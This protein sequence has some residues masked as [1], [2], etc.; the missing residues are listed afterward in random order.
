MDSLKLISILML[1]FLLV[2]E[3]VLCGGDDFD[4]NY[5]I[6]WGFDHVINH[7]RDVHLQL[8]T[9]SGAGFASKHNFGSGFFNMRI[10]LHNK[11]TAGVVTA[12][13]LTSGGNQHDEVDFEFLGDKEGKPIKLQTN[14][15]ANGRGNKEQRISLWFDPAAE[16]HTYGILWNH[17]QIV[18]YV[19]Q[20]PIR[21]FKNNKKMKVGYPTQAMSIQGSIWCGDSWATDGGKTK[22]NWTHAPFLAHFEGGFHIDGCPADEGGTDVKSCYSGRKYWWSSPSYWNLSPEEW[23][24]YQLHK[25]KFITYDYCTDKSRNPVPPLSAL[26]SEGQ[27]QTTQ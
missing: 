21:V 13:Y 25:R 6:T 18:F 9:S 14:V 27:K 10:K 20:I 12:F 19:D 16:Y 11:D 7:E 26:H 1:G 5:K 23:S 4:D 8:D 2:C 17:H 3:R 22:T 24:V 15:I